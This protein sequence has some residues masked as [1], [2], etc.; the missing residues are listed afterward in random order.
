M[1]IVTENCCSVV[2]VV[3]RMDKGCNWY[4]RD[5]VGTTLCNRARRSCLSKLTYPAGWLPGADIQEQEVHMR[6]TRQ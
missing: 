4:G 5:V 3:V 6:S 1:Y 2:P